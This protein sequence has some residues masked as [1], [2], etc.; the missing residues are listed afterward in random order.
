MSKKKVDISKIK[1][2]LYIKDAFLGC[3]A[4]SVTIEADDSVDT[5]CTDGTH[6]KYSTE[7]FSELSFY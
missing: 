2:Q 4:T 1:V 7:F 3:I 5:A 6:I